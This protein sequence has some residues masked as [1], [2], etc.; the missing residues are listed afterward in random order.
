MGVAQGARCCV[1]GFACWYGVFAS[2]SAAKK[3]RP[4]GRIEGAPAL[5]GTVTTA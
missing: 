2:G 4:A 5:P 3:M 1:S